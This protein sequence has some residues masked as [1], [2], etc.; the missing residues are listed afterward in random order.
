MIQFRQ[1]WEPIIMHGVKIKEPVYEDCRFTNHPEAIP[2]VIFLDRIFFRLFVNCEA[3]DGVISRQIVR[4]RGSLSGDDCIV[5]PDCR[6]GDN[7]C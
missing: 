4:P 5:W 1:S 2:C 3:H 7:F 6:H